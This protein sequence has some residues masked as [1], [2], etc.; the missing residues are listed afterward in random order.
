MMSLHFDGRDCMLC[1]APTVDYDSLRQKVGSATVAK[2]QDVQVYIQRLQKA[3]A[4]AQD[5]LKMYL[6]FVTW[7]RRSR[8]DQMVCEFL[9]GS[10]PIVREA[11]AL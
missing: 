6:P 7:I 4:V 5:T 9:E 3:E 11:V 1:Q 2:V 8:R 10:T